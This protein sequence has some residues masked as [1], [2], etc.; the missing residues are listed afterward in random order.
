MNIFVEYAILNALKDVVN[1]LNICK[2]NLTLLIT[3]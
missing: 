1:Y 2:L 3:N